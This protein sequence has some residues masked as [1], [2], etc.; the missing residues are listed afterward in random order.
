MSKPS[1]TSS[2]P[3]SAIAP[4]EGEPTGPHLWQIRWVRDLTLIGVVV[5]AVWL[6]YYLRAIFTPVLIG[7]FLAY[8]AHPL[9]TAMERR[10]RMPRTLSIS[11]LLGA[12]AGVLA[13]MAWWLGPVVV[14]ESGSFIEQ[15]P[16]YL[17]R[18]NDWAQQRFGSNFEQYT[19]QVRREAAKLKADPGATLAHLAGVAMA[20]SGTVAGF[21]QS[22]MGTVIYVLTMLALIPVYFFFFCWHFGPLVSGFRQYLP[23]HRRDEIL[24]IL[25]KMNTAIATFFRGRILISFLMAIMF[26]I[27]WWMCGVP[28]AFLLGL[29]AGFISLI[30]YASI[31]TWPLAIML[32]WLVTPED[33]AFDMWAIVVWPSVVYGVVQFIEG[34]ILT[35]Y[36]QGKALEMSTVT[37]L[38]IVFVGGALGGLY[39]LILCLPAAACL[40]ILF[41]H[42]VQPRLRQ[43]AAEH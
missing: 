15:L 40:K 2:G 14:K 9:V 37:I 32:K 25:G 36:I 11:L 8:L 12:A 4:N 3:G 34:W 43:W 23:T 17:D 35:P 24:D 10:W 33:A 38:I 5:F 42:V 16:G 1:S 6:G 22:V 27:G 19:E 18:L 7:L 39:G 26:W 13:G 41:Q 29:F 31:V 20:G 28:Y 30:P 21:L